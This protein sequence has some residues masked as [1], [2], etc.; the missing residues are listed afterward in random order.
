MHGNKNIN[1]ILN[2]FAPNHYSPQNAYH[3][4]MEYG[5]I[6]C[7]LSLISAL[8]NDLRTDHRTGLSSFNA[9]DLERR[10]DLYGKN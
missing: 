2:M 9:I 10:G 4:L 6:S 5:G 3:L 8:I 7:T 1:L